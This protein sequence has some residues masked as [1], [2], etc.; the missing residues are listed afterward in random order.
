MLRDV[1]TAFISM[2]VF[3]VLLG[4]GYPL[5]VTGIGQ[6]IFPGKSN[7]S[8]IKVGGV[9]IG[10]PLIGQQFYKTEIGNNGKPVLVKGVVQTVPDP[11]YFQTRHRSRATTPPRPS[12]RTSAPTERRLWPP[13][14]VTSRPTSRSTRRPT[15][16]ST[17]P[18]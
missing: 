9:V 6:G 10:S 7:G 1:K 15:G 4:L 16:P 17:T 8:L 5:L 18:P 2:I 13:S 14:R 11:R 12:S 3:T